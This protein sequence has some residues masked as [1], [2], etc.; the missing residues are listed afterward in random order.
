[1]ANLDQIMNHIADCTIVESGETDG[2][3]YRK[4]SNGTAECWKTVEGTPATPVAVGGWYGSYIQNIALPT[5]LFTS[6]PFT[7][8]N[9]V[10]W[11]TGT[12]FT[13][14]YSVTATKFNLSLIRNDNA[15]GISRTHVY[16]FG[17]WN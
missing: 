17:K 11:G 3:T 5:G 6:A 4:W 16:A 15:N 14:I 8:S 1:M 9:S 7:Y 10:S 13:T 2:W 12:H